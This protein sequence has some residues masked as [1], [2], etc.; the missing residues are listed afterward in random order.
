MKK[1]LV[2][3]ISLI[4][5]NQLFCAY[6]VNVPQTITQPNGVTI[7]CFVTGDEF[8]SWLHDS[9]NFT[10]VRNQNTG[11]YSYAMLVDNVLVASPYI[12]G[13]NDPVNSGLTPGINLS[14]QEIITRINAQSLKSVPQNR[15]L[16]K[17]NVA[18]SKT[19]QT[20]QTLNNIVVYIRFSDQDEFPA[21]QNQY[22]T[23]FNGSG[24]SDVSMYNY[25][26]EISYGLSNI[27]STFYPNNN[28]TIIISY[29]DAHT[30]N[31]YRPESIVG[32]SGYCEI[33]P[34]Y[35]EREY[36]ENALIKNALNYVKSQ[37]PMSLNLD[38]NVDGNVDN[39][40]FIVRGNVGGYTEW[41]KI[42]WPHKGTLAPYTNYAINSKYVRNYNFQFELNLDVEVLCHEMG[43]TLGAPDLYHYTNPYDMIPLGNWD[44]MCIGSTIPVSI[45]AYTKYKYMGFINEIPIISSSG[46]YT[47]QPIISST[48]NCYKIQSSNPNEYFVL[49]FRQKTGTFE[50]NI[51]GT[52]LLIYRI[53]NSVAYGNSQGPPDEVYLYRP[54]GTLTNNG[55]YTIA[56]FNS[57][58]SRSIF[59]SLSNPYSF[60][61]DG[62]IENFV[63]KNITV[64]GNS[65]SFDVRLCSNTDITLSNTNMLPEVSNAVNTLN[66]SGSVIVKATD[67]ITFEAGH[68]IILNTG[69]E[70]QQGGQL[71]VNIVTCG[72]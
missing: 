23:Y 2:I 34:C 47:L 71:D 58:N 64:S 3:I 67:R 56:N 1:K 62:S 29:Q 39:I 55:N 57:A 69:F 24:A 9:N 41:N 28:G 43:H 21:S 59:N 20:Q 68:E 7:N 65:I 36:R 51:P 63:I 72:Q 49:E 6:L 30:R 11:Y 46:H 10:I 37:I 27:T 18:K 31:Y 14:N 54:N 70:V 60:L 13:V 22:T 17:S 26:N 4:L 52:G 35:T 19:A 8:Y 40:C 12:V 25:F 44:I 50:S 33:Y 15:L 5:S 42:L 53:N 45:C 48:N 61:S 32:D 16:S 38:G 66:T